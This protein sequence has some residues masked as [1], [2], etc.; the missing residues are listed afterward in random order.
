M[1]RA[2]LR[3]VVTMACNETSEEVQGWL[4]DALFYVFRTQP[5]LWNWKLGER[6]RVAEIFWQLRTVVP[7]AWTVDMEWNRQEKNAVPKLL[8][9]GRYGTPDIVIHHRGKS[10]PENN[11]LVVEFKNSYL[12]KSQETDQLK[13]DKWMMRLK[14]RFGTV[15]SLDRNSRGIFAPKGLWSYQVDNKIYTESWMPR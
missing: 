15:L 14:Y 12:K 5:E 4:T 3:Y 9:P 2:R 10:G 8:E 7:N 1:C 6:A 11:L 13:I